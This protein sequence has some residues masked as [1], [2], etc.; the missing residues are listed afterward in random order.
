MRKMTVS[1][2]V[3]IVVVVLGLAGCG[4]QE[5]IVGTWETSLGNQEQYNADGTYTYTNS[6]FQEL[7]YLEG[8]WEKNENLPA[9]IQADGKTWTVY[10]I[11]DASRTVVGD[12]ELG[13]KYKY[14]DGG[15]DYY[16]LVSEDEAATTIGAGN[17]ERIAEDGELSDIEKSYMSK[18]QL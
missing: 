7:G 18:R 13:N 5:P 2:F 3:A 1:I 17:V 12:G 9:T 6:F 15:G 8:K 16:L 10:L 14:N 4:N 11:I